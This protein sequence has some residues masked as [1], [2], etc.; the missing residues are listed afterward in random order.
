MY[1][2]ADENALFDAAETGI[3]DVRILL[4]AAGGDEDAQMTDASGYFRFADLA[5]GVYM[6]AQEAPAGWSEPTPTGRVALLISANH[7]HQVLFAHQPLPTATPTPTPTA[8][9]SPTPQP[10]LLWLPLYSH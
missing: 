4:T 2:D 3:A 10:H 1:H 7:T 6:L 9:P 5:P 8:T